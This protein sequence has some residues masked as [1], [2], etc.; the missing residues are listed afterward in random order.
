MWLSLYGNGD[1]KVYKPQTGNARIIFLPSQRRQKGRGDHSS[2]TF[3]VELVGGGIVLKN[4]TCSSLLANNQDF[5]GTW[6]VLV[7]AWVDCL[8]LS[9]MSCRAVPLNSV[10]EALPGHRQTGRVKAEAGE[11]KQRMPIMV[12]DLDSSSVGPLETNMGGYK[13]KLSSLDSFW[14]LWLSEA[15]TP[16]TLWVSKVLLDSNPA[17]PP[18]THTDTAALWNNTGRATW[19]CGDAPSA[20]PKPA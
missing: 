12:E 6:N 20:F 17:V 14:E 3:P 16:K 9:T 1:L 2:S 11:K 7:L 4:E 18:Q 8:L 10:A 13:L 5:M 19:L 15:H